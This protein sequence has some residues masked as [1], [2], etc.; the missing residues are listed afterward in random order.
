MAALRLLDRVRTSANLSA[1]FTRL[2]RRATRPV[3]LRLV[4]S[5]K[6]YSV[7]PFQRPFDLHRNLKAAKAAS[8]E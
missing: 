7:R 4:K 8:A 6:N 2:A 5:G 3:V 1:S